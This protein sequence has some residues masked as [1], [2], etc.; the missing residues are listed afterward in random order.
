[1]PH[2]GSLS[3]E[4]PAAHASPAA[5][6]DAAGAPASASASAAAAAAA[7]AV[8]LPLL[9]TVE[10]LL[11]RLCPADRRQLL[12][13]VGALS[14]GAA[15]GGAAAA[16]PPPPAARAPAVR[17]A[18]LRLQRGLLLRH[19]LE[20]G[21]T[22]DPEGAAD[23]AG[24]LRA[25]PRALWLM[26]DRSPASSR[27]RAPTAIPFWRA[28]AMGLGDRPP[29]DPHYCLVGR[30]ACSIA[31][32]VGTLCTYTYDAHPATLGAPTPAPPGSPLRCF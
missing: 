17:A 25:A 24:W 29:L 21:D 19:L 23:M 26:G 4:V 11:P 12:S 3:A 6:S 32:H 13:A 5:K 20:G 30:V 14:G 28:A 22:A 31:A 27:V 8:A 2:A 16:P 10:R 18:C 15:P 9:R 1:V 7:A